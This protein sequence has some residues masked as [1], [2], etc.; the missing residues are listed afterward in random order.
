MLGK[1]LAT[2]VL[3]FEPKGLEQAAV[4]TIQNEDALLENSFELTEATFG[5]VYTRWNSA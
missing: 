5:H 3:L 2:I 4:S 1:P